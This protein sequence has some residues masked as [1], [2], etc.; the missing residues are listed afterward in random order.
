M[1]IFEVVIPYLSTDRDKVL[2]TTVYSTNRKNVMQFIRQHKIDRYKIN[3]LSSDK[4]H[5][6]Y[7]ISDVL[8]EF[9]FGSNKSNDEYNIMTTESLICE[10]VDYISEMLI[11]TLM[12]GPGILRVEFPI[13]D[14]INN[15]IESLKHTQIID[16]VIMDSEYCDTDDEDFKRHYKTFSNK[17]YEMEDCPDNNDHIY[18]YVHDSLRGASLLHGCGIEA[19]TLEGY[20]EYIASMLTDII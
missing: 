4:P 5:D 2:T 18:N 17:Y 1:D 13:I 14:F 19:I 10:A 9:T 16:Y 20:V 3:V 8:Q 6:I 12:F 11:Q 15:E 7:D